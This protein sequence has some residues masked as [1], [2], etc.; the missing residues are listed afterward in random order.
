MSE[1][2]VRMTDAEYAITQ[3]QLQLAVA[4]MRELDL[5]AFLVRI[6]RCEAVAPLLAPSLYIE[7]AGKLEQLKRVAVAALALQRAADATQ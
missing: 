7:G 2:G 1:E 6:E 3:Q 5:R 4:I